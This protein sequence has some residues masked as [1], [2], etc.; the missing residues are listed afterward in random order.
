MKKLYTSLLLA[1]AL[2]GCTATSAANITEA[3]KTEISDSN[4]FNLKVQH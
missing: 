1:A 4:N 3:E 2:T